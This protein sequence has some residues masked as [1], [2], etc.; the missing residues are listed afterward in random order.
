MFLNGEVS[1]NGIFRV[2]R[3][4]QDPRL[5]YATFFLKISFVVP[6]E[7]YLTEVIL[8]TEYR[9]SG[10]VIEWFMSTLLD[11]GLHRQAC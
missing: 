6:D 8:R 3:R 11:V 7:T 4:K 5:L 10:Q 2:A 9:I 1:I